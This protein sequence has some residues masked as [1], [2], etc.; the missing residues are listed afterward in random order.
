MEA[1]TQKYNTTFQKKI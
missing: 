1:I